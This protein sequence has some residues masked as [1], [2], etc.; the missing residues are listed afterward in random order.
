[1]RDEG[2]AYARKLADAGVTVELKRFPELIH[3]FINMVGLD[4]PARSAVDE[5]I[6]K[7]AAA[8]R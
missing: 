1:L 7:L 6:G 2:E 8:L 5:V 4:I 3:G